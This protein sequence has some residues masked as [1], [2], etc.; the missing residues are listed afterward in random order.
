MGVGGE[1]YGRSRGQWL[2]EGESRGLGG[3]GRQ[4]RSI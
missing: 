2:G 3:C 4:E 1:G